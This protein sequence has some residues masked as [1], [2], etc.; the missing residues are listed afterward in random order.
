MEFNITTQRI[1]CRKMKYTNGAWSICYD[2]YDFWIPPRYKSDPFI[3]WNVKNNKYTPINMFPKAYID[4]DM[5]FIWIYHSGEFIYAI[6]E[7]ANMFVKIDRQTLSIHKEYQIL[8]NEKIG[9]FFDSETD[10]YLVLKDKN[11]PFFNQKGN[12]FLKLHKQSSELTDFSFFLEN[13]Q[14][15]IDEFLEI[16]QRRMF[17]I[18]RERKAFGLEELLANI[19]QGIRPA[20]ADTGFDI[21][22]GKRIWDEL[23][24]E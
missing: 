13:R 5:N 1:L 9:F 3:R 15:L 7:L 17:D 19:I 21:G 4:C 12:R 23:I 18:C 20:Q 6:P 11:I 2:G 24:K 16:S 22:N 10:I 8:D 14:A